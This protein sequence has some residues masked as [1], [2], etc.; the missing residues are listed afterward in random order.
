M[1]V[2]VPVEKN[3]LNPPVSPEFGKSRWFVLYDTVEE[4]SSIIENLYSDSLGDAGVHSAQMLIEKNVD[5]AIIESAGSNSLRLLSAAGI[6]V[7]KSTGKSA[8]EALDLLIDDKLVLV[9]APAEGRRIKRRRR[10]GRTNRR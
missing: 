1:I 3:D 8:A 4:A 2:A 10:G 6:K 7:Y 5:A 9:L